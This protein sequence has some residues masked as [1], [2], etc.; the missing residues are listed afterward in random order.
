[1]EDSVTVDDDDT[2]GRDRDCVSVAVAVSSLVP[3]RDC[4]GVRTLSL[5]LNE[6]V[7]EMEAV[8]R[9]E[10]WVCSSDSELVMEKFLESDRVIVCDCDAAPTVR[11][12]TAATSTTVATAGRNTAAGAEDILH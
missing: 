9:E 7:K 12:N 2:L 10:V 3:V 5:I 6:F 11:A 8:P 4:E 1:V